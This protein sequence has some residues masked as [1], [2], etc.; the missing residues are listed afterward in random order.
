VLRVAVMDLMALADALLLRLGDGTA[1]GRLP[2]GSA[3]SGFRSETIGRLR[4][5]ET[6]RNP[7]MIAP[8]VAGGSKDR[9]TDS[10]NV[11]FESSNQCLGIGSG[12]P[13]Q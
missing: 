4:V 12:D 6:L 11:P 1:N 5:N 7:Q 13:L 8:L 2:P 10:K 9:I 3:Q